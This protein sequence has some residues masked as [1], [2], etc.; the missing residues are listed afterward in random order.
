MDVRQIYDSFFLRD[1]LAHIVPGALVLLGLGLAVSPQM[2]VNLFT[3][4]WTF[5]LVVIVPLAYASGLFVSHLACLIR[6][7]AS[8][9]NWTLLGDPYDAANDAAR[10]ERASTA[11]T[12]EAPQSDQVWGAVYRSLKRVY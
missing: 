7:S 8:D 5:Q 9:H 11:G 2:V 1:V 12:H 3:W 4:N 6:V 10:E